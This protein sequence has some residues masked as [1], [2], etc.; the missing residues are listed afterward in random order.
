MKDLRTDDYLRHIV[1][2][3]ADILSFVSGSTEDQ[4][5]SD[6]R[7]QKAVIMSL[8]EI[9]EAATKIASTD[10]EFVA[11]NP[12]VPWKQMKGMRNR[13][14]HG[15][16]DIDFDIVW[17]TVVSAIPAL[18]KQTAELLDEDDLSR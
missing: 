10:P 9:G 6:R 14:A 4:F 3:T 11:R 7:T 16:F 12:H 5:K 13:I 18:N 1:D 15:Y 8:I 2:S 17:Q